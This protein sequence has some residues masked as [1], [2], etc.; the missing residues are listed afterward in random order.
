M[1]I[2]TQTLKKMQGLYENIENS[3]NQKIRTYIQGQIFYHLQYIQKELDDIYTICGTKTIRLHDYIQRIEEN[4]AAIKELAHQL[5]FPFMLFVMGNGKNGKST[6]INALL[7]QQ[8]AIEDALPK[9]WKIDV[10]HTNTTNKCILSFKDGTKKELNVP[11]THA[12]IL[13]EERKRKESEKKIRE[14]LRK[15]KQT[16]V[17]LEA[18]EEKQRE[19]RKYKLYQSPLIEVSWPLQNSDILNHYQL[20]DTPGLR[21]ELDD[22]L[23]ASAESYFSK[24]DGIIW[25]LPGDKI[26]SAGDH[27]EL[28]ELCKKYEKHPDNIIAVINRMDIV[29]ASG[30]NT[31]DVLDEA[32]RFYGD[33]FTEIVPISAKQ[34]RQSDELLKQP[35][36]TTEDRKQGEALW[37]E[38]NIPELLKLLNYTFFSNALDIQIR[39][40][41]RGCRDL[42]NNIHQ[43]SCNAIQL[44]SSVSKERDEKIAAWNNDCK[45]LQ[46]ILQQDFSTLTKQETERIRKKTAQMENALWDMSADYRN[47]Y[48]LNNIICP[49]VLEKRLNDLIA[50]QSKQLSH[51]SQQ[52]IQRA[53]FK[54]FPILKKTELTT[55]LANQNILGDANLSDDIS[56]QNEAQLA[57]GGALAIGAAA[58]LGPIGLLFAGFAATDWGRSIAKFLSRTFG[59]SMEEKVTSRFTNQMNAINKKLTEEYETYIQTCDKS[60]SSLRESTYAELYGPAEQTPLLLNH[61][62]ALSA[63]QKMDITELHIKDII[64]SK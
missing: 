18:L 22:I 4:L 19:L 17:S 58:L 63:L 54:E 36:C 44:L 33:I 24:A 7:Q 38:S 51:L 21:Q 50:K 8:A 23:I 46:T 43:E 37:Q 30:Q 47:T 2:S 13:E 16:N 29:K 57:L 28:R 64:F 12:Y 41:L 10:F 49:D 1:M 34:A 26:A 60:I 59:S 9:T 6:L 56:G 20:V 52:H 5:D 55:S 3:Y 45:D 35:N 62:H 61:L 48:I 25:I 11:N 27:T 42:L 31:Q 40:K 14:E 53:P 15:F 39:S 32:R